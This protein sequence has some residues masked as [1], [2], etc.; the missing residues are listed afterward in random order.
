MS[1][2]SDF[3]S[4]DLAAMD[5]ASAIAELKKTMAA[6]TKEVACVVLRVSG[7][8][9]E[10][11][12]DHRKV[13]EVLGSVPTVVGGVRSLDVLAVAQ[14]DQ[15]KGKVTKH[16]LPDTFDKPIRGDIVLLRTDS[17]AS[18]MPFMAKEFKEWADAGF[19]DDA[20]QEEDEGEELMDEEDED[21]GEEEG[22]ED[23][24]A[25]AREELEK[26]PTGDLKKA[27][28]MMEIETT[29][30]R[31]EL[32]ERLIEATASD[33]ESD[34]EGDGEESE[35][36]EEVDEE[37]VARMAAAIEEEVGKLDK[38]Q[39]KE[40]CKQ[41]NLDTT[42][43]RE[44]LAARVI[45]AGKRA[46]SDSEDGEDDDEDDDEDAEEEEAV[47]PSA[48]P[49]RKAKASPATAVSKGPRKTI[50]KGRIA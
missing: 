8:T 45:E 44:T 46:D 32:I 49:S 9:E 1:P 31:E 5:T 7:E 27:C 43:D 37:E 29:G 6:P 2:L 24:E 22:E 14:R 20:E 41:M 40:A 26:L 42:G 15:K 10:I 13:N 17:D 25:D 12:I 30:T 28:K 21:D 35:D 39:L 18:P 3:P 34:E 47:P 33:G 11:T 38:K 23:E 4:T 48:K 36:D 19:P 50:A 16:E